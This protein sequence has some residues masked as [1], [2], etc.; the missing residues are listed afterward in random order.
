LQLGT[1]TPALVLQLVVPCEFEQ[2]RPHPSQLAASI[3]VSQPLAVVPSQLR[4]PALQLPNV[5][6]PVV[7]EAL[8]LVKPQAVLHE[9]QSVS[10]RML[11]SHPL[12][13]LPSQLSKP[14]LHPGLQTPA[15]QLGVPFSAVQ[16]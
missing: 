16:L 10:V 11:R 6:V 12:S 1:H 8:A 13:G 3:A 15:L 14:A 4:K 5:Q 2:P 7:H 9:P